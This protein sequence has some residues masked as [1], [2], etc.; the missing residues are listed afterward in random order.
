[1][2]VKMFLPRSFAALKMTPRVVPSIPHKIIVNSQAE[3]PQR[4]SAEKPVKICGK[5]SGK[6][7]PLI[8]G[9]E[10]LIFAEAF[11]M[12][13]HR[14]LAIAFTP[15]KMTTHVVSYMRQFLRQNHREPSSRT[16]SA[17]I[18]GK[19]SENLRENILFR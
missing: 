13:L 1:M 11:G 15:L 16:P 19:I 12:A 6:S 10:T 17:E 14:S 5:P 8:Y 3:R 4:K 18:S 2:M 7:F 9:D